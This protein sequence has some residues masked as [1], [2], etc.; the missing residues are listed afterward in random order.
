MKMLNTFKNM[1]LKGS[2]K[3]GFLQ[4]SMCKGRGTRGREGQSCKKQYFVTP[5]ILGFGLTK[6]TTKLK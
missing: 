5:I 2:A 6:I 4:L 1:F 3:S